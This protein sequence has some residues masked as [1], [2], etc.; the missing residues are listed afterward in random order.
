[1]YFKYC[2]ISSG[3]GQSGY[4]ESKQPVVEIAAP[5]YCPLV[6]QEAQRAVLRAAR[7][8]AATSLS[9]A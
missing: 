2:D 4:V 1:M 7:A 8:V 3:R 6:A 5:Q 9:Y